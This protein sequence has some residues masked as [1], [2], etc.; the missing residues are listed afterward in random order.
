MRSAVQGH[1]QTE[2]VPNNFEQVTTFIGIVRLRQ[3]WL[4]C[5]HLQQHR[6][7]VA[8]L[9]G[10]SYSA[11]QY[12]YRCSSVLQPFIQCKAVEGLLQPADWRSTWNKG[13]WQHRCLDSENGCCYLPHTV[14]W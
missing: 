6:M 10:C 1:K 11:A 8:C 9:T 2:R 5:I 12:I 3:I 13:V 4:S 7:H 14:P